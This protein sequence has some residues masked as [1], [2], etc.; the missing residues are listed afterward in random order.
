MADPHPLD[1]KLEPE[2]RD[3]CQSGADAA[4]LSIAV[5]LKRIADAVAPANGQDLGTTIFFA[6]QAVERFLGSR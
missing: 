4:L 1:G 5:S 6:G 3:G 2:A